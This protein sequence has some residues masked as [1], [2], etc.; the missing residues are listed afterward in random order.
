MIVLDV[1][2]QQALELAEQLLDL[3]ADRNHGGFYF[4]ASDQ[5]KL[6][7]RPK[8]WQDEAM[9]SGNA[10]AAL[11]LSRLGLLIGR[12]DFTA[13]AERALQSVADNVNQTPFYAAGFTAL[14][15][16]SSQPP[17]QIIVRG[18]GEDLEA[19]RRNILP[20]LLP[21]QSAYFIPDSAADLPDLLASKTSN[22]AVSAWICEG[23]SC[24]APITDLK[25]LIAAL[26]EPTS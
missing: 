24:R 14:L 10:V 25:T 6:I 16:A 12:E 20:R 18:S 15:Q 21:D 23:F 8:S 22:E 17:M 5:E 9:P 1:S 11:A 19:W 7:Q 2:D 13:S 4:T 3:F 26:E